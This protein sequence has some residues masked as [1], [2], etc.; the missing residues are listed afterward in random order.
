MKSSFKYFNN[1]MEKTPD[2]SLTPSKSPLKIQTIDSKVSTL[3][4]TASLE[5]KVRMVSYQNKIPSHAG[6]KE[7]NQNQA[8]RPQN[9]IS[10]TTG[11]LT[12]K[13]DEIFRLRKEILDFKEKEKRYM[14]K[15]LELEKENS[16]LIEMTRQNEREFGQRIVQ[17]QSEKQEILKK[18]N[19]LKA[20]VEQ[21]NIKN[22]R[23]N[24]YDDTDV[25][26]KLILDLNQKMVE[27]EKNAVLIMKEKRSG[28]ENQSIMEE[29]IAKSNDVWVRK[30]K[31]ME[32]VIFHLHNENK[33]LKQYISCY[34]E[35]KQEENENVE[36]NETAHLPLPSN[37]K[38][39]EMAK[40]INH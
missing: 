39:I 30:C 6:L 32:F 38:I 4:N 19:D 27:I 34:W 3:V 7:I 29:N 11:S 40:K 25:L 24:S 31:E 26:L 20:S 8:L 28:K 36:N 14:G 23:R 12:E 18:Y 35:N 33:H 21:S 22:E 13:N 9:D 1:F 10:R 2:K 17:N 15:I 37:L 16:R 5:E